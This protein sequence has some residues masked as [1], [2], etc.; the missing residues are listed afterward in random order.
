VAAGAA[1]NLPMT[2]QDWG[3]NLTVVGRPF[4]GEQDY[5]WATHRIASQEY[6]HTMGMRLLNGR[7]FGV[8]DTRDTPRVSVINETF[9]RKAWP[10]ENPI[11]KRF[12]IGDY[13]KYAGDPITVIGVVAD[14]KYMGLADES[15]PEM[16][17][18]MDQEG[19]LN[20]MTFVFRAAQDPRG[21]L[22]TVR[23]VI[24]SIDPNQPITK[25]T[26]LETLVFES[27]APQR[28]T[29]LVGSLFGI[30]AL[31]LAGTGLYGMVSYSVSQRRHEIGVR[32]AM[33]APRGRVVRLVV[34]Q[35]LK[36]TLV[37]LAVGLLAAISLGRLL[38]GL[39][40]QVSPRDPL[41]LVG[42]S[43]A[44]AVI[45]LA[46]SYLPARRAAETDPLSALRCN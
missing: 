8:A 22:G 39:L 31:V 27:A 40:F 29:T 2:G 12:R 15:W 10:T 16:F 28:L 36:L 20:H 13:P 38:S 11:G 6:F 25:A 5:I 23:G 44:F 9:A 42:V 4:R 24:H 32:M 45:A 41:I 43:V 14:A 30:L 21:L 7:S 19:A 1:S 26:T 3:Q 34:G 46:A 35:A 37:G 33:G 17:F 18:S